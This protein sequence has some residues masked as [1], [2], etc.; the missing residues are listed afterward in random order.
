MH[1]VSRIP[2]ER[3]GPRLTLPAGDGLGLGRY[4]HFLSA[5]SWLICGACYLGLMFTSDQW[6]RLTP[7]SWET[8]PCAWR[9]F[10]AY[11]RLESPGPHPP[12]NY[13]PALPFNALQQLAYF[14]VIYVLTGQGR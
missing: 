7:T 6:R 2:R 9:T 10:V 11:L 4:W 1:E 13:D 8:V 14:G 12:F 3:G 5:L